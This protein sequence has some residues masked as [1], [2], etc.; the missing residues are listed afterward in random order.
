MGWG[1]KF[2]KLTKKIT[3]GVIRGGLA[4]VTG[5]MSELGGSHSLGKT[6]SNIANKGTDIIGS[7]LEE[8]T[9]E[10]AKERQ[11]A[12]AAAAAQ[13]QAEQEAADKAAADRY[14]AS[15]LGQRQQRLEDALSS[16]TDFTG[17]EEEDPRKLVDRTDV[18]KR[19]KLIGF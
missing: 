2:K 12:K 9:G 15:I 6:A 1:K 5:G 14:K 13:A 11:K 16:Q 10:A 3:S 7:G 8:L 4:A 17:D 18:S 19:K